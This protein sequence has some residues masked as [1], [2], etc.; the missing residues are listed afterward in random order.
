MSGS[1]SFFHV[2]FGTSMQE[3]LALPRDRAAAVVRGRI[4]DLL[5]MLRQGAPPGEADAPRR[6][7]RL[8]RSLEAALVDALHPQGHDLQSL[9]DRIV[10]D[11][12]MRSE[13][14]RDQNVYLGPVFTRVLT[15][16]I[17]D[18]VFQPTTHREVEAAL[19]W[20][21]AH[22]LGITTRGAGSTAMGGAVPNDGGLLLEMSRFDS[23][24]VDRADGVAV[25]GAGARLKTIHAELARAGLSLLAYPSNLGGTL[26]GWFSAGGLGLNSFTHG[27]VQRQVRALSMVLPRSE[28]VRF[29]DDG[30]LDVLS[31]ETKR[32][33]PEQ[34]RAWLE[35]RG[36]PPLGL[37]DLSQTEGQ[38]GVILTLTMRVQA[39]PRLVARYF[40]VATDAHAIDLCNWIARDASEGGY[41]PANLKF[42][43]VAHVAA[44][45]RVRG[46]GTRA[47]HAAVYVDFETAADADALTARIGSA[48]HSP[49]GDDAEARRW[50]GDRFRPQQTKRLG[51][52]FIA[53]EILMPW[54]ETAA[55]HARAVAL[56]ARVGV[57]LE[58]E[59]YWFGDGRV[60]VLPGYLSRGP[61]AGF[62]WEMILAPVLLDAAMAHHGG[63]PY[64][65]GRWQSPYFKHKH[66]RDAQQKLRDH[67]KRIDPR[68]TLN[69]GVYYGPVFRVPG[70]QGVF[71]VTF[72]GVV[73][74]LRRFYGNAA[75]AWMFRAAI[76]ARHDDT[77][78]VR[79]SARW[80]DPAADADAL[81]L[82]A[83][84]ERWSAG[85]LATAARGCVNC[86][87]CNTVCPIFHDARIRL[88]QMLTHMGERA[89]DSRALGGTERLLLDLCMRCGNCQ[90]VCQADVPHLPLYAA[91]ERRAGTMDDERRERH[92]GILSHLRHSERYSQAFLGVRPGGYLQRTP[93]SLPGEVRFVLFRAENDAGAE[94]TCIHC[95]ACVPVCPTSANLEFKEEADPRRIST[96]LSRCIG[97]GTCVEVCPANAHNGG[98]TLRVME[99]PNREFFERLSAFEARMEGSPR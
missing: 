76:A 46:D 31:P 72:P 65:L 98:R 75:T 61:R 2:H 32:L 95:G 39:L 69:P 47:A 11:G 86:G 83:D 50:L 93:A 53:A 38:F 78:P 27:P 34:A 22:R 59:A 28:H 80:G 97:C 14:D 19:G 41:A 43:S 71:R 3:F 35:E 73:R 96:D 94:D 63:S 82:A 58:T 1:S 74:L 26:A 16:A 70:V 49:R 33:A 89:G 88:P 91:L 81:R 21:R 92:V 9:R 40:E 68:R 45:R 29:H 24:H 48:P 52:G 10:T 99:A 42:L 55:F 36:Y 13:L 77:H 30:R 87:E 85:D 23:V 51:P 15:R 44:V 67:K 4:P 17:P 7:V 20:A 56:A 5:H 8:A 54:R 18:L 79:T 25:I 84:L 12:F 37:D 6:T 66:D 62:V 60:L 90:E 64:V 57:H